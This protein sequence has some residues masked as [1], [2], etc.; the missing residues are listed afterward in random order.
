MIVV[1]VIDAPGKRT[2]V[3]TLCGVCTKRSRVA[4]TQWQQRRWVELVCAAG[5]K[6]RVCEVCE[7][8]ALRSKEGQCVS[9][10]L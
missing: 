10:K 4:E 8:N 1:H 7:W 6:A 3:G 5:R 9:K 2:D